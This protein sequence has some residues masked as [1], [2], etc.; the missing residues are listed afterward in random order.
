MICRQLLHYLTVYW[1]RRLHSVSKERIQWVNGIRDIRIIDMHIERFMKRTK[2]K[3]STRNMHDMSLYNVKKMLIIGIDN[4]SIMLNGKLASRLGCICFVT[5]LR[6]FVQIY[7][8]A[9]A[10][11]LK[12]A[13]CA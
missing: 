7:V 12:I 4:G 5:S 1:Q 9:I 8:R 13:F 10:F 2:M 11:L 3:M 6:E